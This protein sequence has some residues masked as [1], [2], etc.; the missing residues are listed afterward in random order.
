MKKKPQ[1]KKIGEK[2]N[3]TS[4]KTKSS[5]TK[6]QKIKAEQKNTP[7]KNNHNHQFSVI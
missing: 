7:Q 4:R 5:A 1:T 3:K 2:T 6:K